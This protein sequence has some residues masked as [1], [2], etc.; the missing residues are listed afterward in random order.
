MA[1]KNET[2]ETQTNTKPASKKKKTS[3]EYD[4]QSIRLL[5]GADRVRLRPAV[6]FG[7][8]GIEGCEHAFFEILSNSVDEAREGYGDLITVTVYNDRS[9]EVEDRGRGIPL[10]Y[11]EEEQRYNWDLIFC[12]LYAGGKYD[13]TKSG[14]YEFSLG[15]NGLGACATQ[16]ASEYM[17]VRSYKN[18]S[19]SSISFKK[20]NV[21]SELTVEPLSGKEINRTGTV[22]R[23]R[24]DLEVF[25]SIDLRRDNI[26]SVVHKQAIVNAGVTFKLRWQNEDGTFTEENHTYANGITD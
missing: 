16:Y 25:T 3:Q 13:N 9:I 2:T 8:D 11:N 23:W 14:N 15:T 10:G 4:E 7:S 26:S 20:G 22:I 21:C 6:I 18:G 24:P 19:V 12:E 5:K 1:K 17:D